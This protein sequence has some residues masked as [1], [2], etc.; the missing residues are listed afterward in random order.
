MKTITSVLIV[1]LLSIS[2]N[3]QSPIEKNVG[4]F[5]TVKVFDLIHVSLVKSDEEK[6][7]ISG[8]D[9]DAVQVINKN[10]VLKI[11][12]KIDKVFDGIKTF[13][14]IHYK[15]LKVIDANEGSRIVGNELIEQEEI[16]LRAQEGATIKV[17]LDVR[18]VDI[19]AVTGG[20]I[21][22]RGKALSQKIKI[23]TGGIYD[24]KEFITE[25]TTVSI[26]AGGEADVNASKLVDAKIRAGG[27][28]L[29]FGNPKTINKD[30]IFGGS[31][32]RKK[33]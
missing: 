18:H 11:R 26:K 17:G 5:S 27:D 28:I 4:E 29:I 33:S 30:R 22:T 32:K 1:L 8:E 13:V 20:I 24:G 16:E 15:D 21:E 9:T 19:R 10:G 6:V 31:I 2:L 23:N 7:I 14:A 25:T 3:A 12:M